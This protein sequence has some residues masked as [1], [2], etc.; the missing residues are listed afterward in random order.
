MNFLRHAI[1]NRVTTYKSRR[2]SRS[3][4]RNVSP[5]RLAGNIKSKHIY[6]APYTSQANEKRI[7]AET[8]QSVHVHYRRNVKQLSL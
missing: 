3:A 5:M 2:D 6:I 8:R 4:M 7:V 1:P